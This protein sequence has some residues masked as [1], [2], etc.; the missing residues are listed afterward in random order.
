MQTD[1]QK[2]ME[3]RE[4]SVD[5]GVSTLVCHFL[6]L[7]LLIGLDHGRLLRAVLFGRLLETIIRNVIASGSRPVFGPNRK[8]RVVSGLFSVISETQC[9]T[10]GRDGLLTRRGCAPGVACIWDGVWVCGVLCW[11]ARVREK[12]GRHLIVFSLAE[13]SVESRSRETRDG[14]LPTAT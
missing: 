9:A 8:G 6:A 13:K 3:R 2:E 12:C 10:I 1:R 5:G 4:C 7:G 11:D 14:K